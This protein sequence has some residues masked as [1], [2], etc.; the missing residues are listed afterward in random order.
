MTLTVFATGLARLK[1]R[2]L[3]ATLTISTLTLGV[4]TLSACSDDNAVSQTQPTTVATATKVTPSVV[5]KVGYENK[6]GEPFDIGMQRWKEELEKLSNGTMSLELYPNSALGTKN[7]IINRMRQGEPVVTLADGAVYY[8][9]GA[10]DMGITFGPFLFKN[11][12]EAFRLLNSKWY[13]GLAD[14]MAEEQGM[15]IISSNWAYGIRHLLTKQ[16]ITKVEDLKGLRIRVPGNAIQSN[17]FKIYGATPVNLE[18]NQVNAALQKN[19][20]DGLENPIP[21]LQAGGI[22]KYAPNLLLTGH[23]YTVTNLIMS[24]QV[25]QRLNTNQKQLLRDSCDRAAKFANIVQAAFEY[26]SLQQ[27]IAEGAKVSEPS[28]EL[29]N[30]L[31][32]TSRSFYFLPEFDSK[33][34]PGLYY[35]VLSAKAI[36]FS[37]YTQSEH[38][39]RLQQLRRAA[40][41]H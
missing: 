4:L 36:P 35:K 5:L 15:R 8:N 30:A 21:T 13:S 41:S 16:P 37:F 24:E 22:H 17:T 28:P 19:E 31:I 1:A 34:S 25:W 29:L 7:D 39:K 33:W 10:Y 27:M 23:V 3:A 2:V 26:S 18:L 9:F 12:D 14:K 38:V 32:S 40:Q 20:I 6:V 11:W